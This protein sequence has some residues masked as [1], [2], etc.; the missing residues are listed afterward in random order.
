MQDAP[1]TGHKTITEQFEPRVSTTLIPK[2]I[3]KTEKN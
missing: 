2:K 1:K 3:Q